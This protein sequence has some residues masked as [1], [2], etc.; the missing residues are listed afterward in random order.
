MDPDSTVVFYVTI[1]TCFNIMSVNVKWTEMKKNIFGDYF[2]LFQLILYD[3]YCRKYELNG[4][5]T[6][7]FCVICNS[8]HV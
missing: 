3:L 6:G 5:K 2:L 7:S 4:L 1:W 8:N